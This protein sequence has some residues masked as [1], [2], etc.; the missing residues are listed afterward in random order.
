MSDLFLTETDL[1][2]AGSGVA[3]GENRHGMS[4][5]TVTFGAVGAVPDNPLEKGAAQ[6]V[7]GIGERR[8]EAIAFT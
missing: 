6:D 1:A 7:A 4:F 5:P 8:G 3:D 2:D